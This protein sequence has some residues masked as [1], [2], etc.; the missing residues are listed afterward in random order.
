MNNLTWK[1]T[2]SHSRGATDRT[3][4]EWTCQ[5]KTL[6]VVLHRRRLDDPKVWFMS[7]SDINIDGRRLEAV[8]V[9]DA[10]AEA[11]ELLRANLRN[12][13]AEVS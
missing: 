6:R 13:L 1:D 8:D 9:D 5:T 7:C 4:R 12:L 2:T 11:L 10:K 3:P